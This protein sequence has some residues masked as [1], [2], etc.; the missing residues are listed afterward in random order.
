MQKKFE[1][2]FCL[3]DEPPRYELILWAALFIIS[4]ALILITFILIGNY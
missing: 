1:S 4:V 3:I 2:F